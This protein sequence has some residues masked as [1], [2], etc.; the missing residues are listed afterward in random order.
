MRGKYFVKEIFLHLYYCWCHY[1][2]AYDYI[3]FG[4]N[5]S[6]LSVALNKPSVLEGVTVCDVVAE[7]LNAMHAAYKAYIASES[8]EKLR[9]TL[10]H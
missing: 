3:T 10:R 9:R 6:L 4:K 7:N 8:S 5:P 2:S 1:D